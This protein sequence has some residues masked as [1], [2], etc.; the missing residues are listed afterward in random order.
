M[1]IIKF[2]DLSN[3]EKLKGILRCSGTTKGYCTVVRY[4][5]EYPDSWEC[6][7]C[8]RSGTVNSL[9]NTEKAYNMEIPIYTKF[10]K[11]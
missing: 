4:E 10:S 8:G 11:K 1:K 2:E 5:E 6:P 9:K 7:C 3:E